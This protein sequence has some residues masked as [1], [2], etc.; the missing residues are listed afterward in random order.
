M[1]KAMR[2]AY[3]V[4]MDWNNNQEYW[5]MFYLYL[6]YMNVRYDLHIYGS[7]DDV[8]QACWLDDI[9]VFSAVT[10]FISECEGFE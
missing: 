10:T 6:N 2:G 1:I 8:I 7:L 3:K 4:D 5:N 9:D